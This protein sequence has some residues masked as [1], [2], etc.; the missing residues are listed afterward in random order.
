M[1]KDIKKEKKRNIETLILIRDNPD[2]QAVVVVQ[3][4]RTMQKLLTENDPQTDK[5]LK[6]LMDIRDN[7]AIKSSIRVMAMQT[8]NSM[9]DI[10]GDTQDERPTESDIMK[11]IRSN[12]T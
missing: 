9:F 5:N 4:V 3:A 7:E 1:P 6:A 8:L 12:K 2:T 11:K 10:L